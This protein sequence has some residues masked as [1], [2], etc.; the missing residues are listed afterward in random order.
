MY[1]RMYTYVYTDIRICT[2]ILMLAVMPCSSPQANPPSLDQVEDVTDLIH[3]NETS[4]VHV[5][6]QRY[7]SSLIH[8]YAGRHMMIINP[9]RPLASYSDKVCV[10]WSQYSSVHIC[11]CMCTCHYT[12]LHIDVTLSL[13]WDYTHSMT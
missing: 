4:V 7:A 6:R 9:V 3:L 5:L 2:Y 10:L 13:F 12:F 1:I 11:T 8:T